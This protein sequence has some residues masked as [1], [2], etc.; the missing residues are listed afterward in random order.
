[1]WKE[2]SASDE[3]R[4]IRQILTLSFK[5]HKFPYIAYPQH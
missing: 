2:E 5:A 4:G 3:Q 1:V